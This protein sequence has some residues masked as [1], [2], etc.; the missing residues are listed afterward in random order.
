MEKDRVLCTIMSMCTYMSFVN[1]RFYSVR[2]LQNVIQSMPLICRPSQG[3]RRQT[4][5]LQFS[6]QSVACHH[7]QREQVLVCCENLCAYMIKGHWNELVI[8]VKL[9]IEIYQW[10]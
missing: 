2:N 4:V 7:Q 3:R 10:M 9:K 5:I 6:L 1:V 8:V